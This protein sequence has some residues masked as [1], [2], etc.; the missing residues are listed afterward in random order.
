MNSILDRLSGTKLFH[1]QP[2]RY[3]LPCFGCRT[4]Y[5]ADLPSCPVCECRERVPA[6][7]AEHGEDSKIG[8]SESSKCALASELRAREVAGRYG[9]EFID[10][11]NFS[12]N[13]DILEKVP[14]DLMLRY[15]FVPLEEMQD[16]RLVIAIADPSQLMMIDE[17]S[18]LLGK[19]LM[20]RVAALTQ[21]IEV[22][23]NTD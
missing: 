16:G 14:V 12:L 4:Y 13:P 23:H 15:S 19:R 2:V 7:T 10:L 9:C 22:L 20:V 1:P 11:R 3:G 8:P 5:S 18:V 17:I 6:R 21:I